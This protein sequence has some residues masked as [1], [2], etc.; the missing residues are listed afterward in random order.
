MTEEL[1]HKFLPLEATI[2]MKMKFSFITDF[3]INF[4]KYSDNILTNLK[5]ST[6]NIIKYKQFN[7]PAVEAV[8]AKYSDMGFKMTIEPF[9]K[10]YIDL[11]AEKNGIIYYLEPEVITKWLPEDMGKYPYK[12]L[13]LL[14]RKWKY[15]KLENSYN[16]TVR[17]D[18]KVMYSTPYRLLTDE[19]IYYNSEKVKNSRSAEGEWMCNIDW[20]NMSKRIELN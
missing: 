19:F 20:K 13:H 11:M 1:E 4:K 6:F 18:L 8:Y 5:I 9:G 3:I 12:K 14:S 7:Y 15:R 2:E 16:I 10:L 17:S